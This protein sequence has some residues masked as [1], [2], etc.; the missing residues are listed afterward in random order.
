MAAIAIL[1]KKYDNI[2]VTKQD[3]RMRMLKYAK[4]TKSPYFWRGK[5]NEMFFSRF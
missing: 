3:I 2:I 4:Y 1:K 5:T